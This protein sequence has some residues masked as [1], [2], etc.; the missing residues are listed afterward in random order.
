MTEQPADSR[1]AFRPSPTGTRTDTILF[2]VSMVFWVAVVV[3]AAAAPSVGSVAYGLVGLGFLA[4]NWRKYRHGVVAD[5]A[6]LHRPLRRVLPWDEVHA[7]EEP[8]ELRPELVLWCTDGKRRGTLLPIEYADELSRISGR[9]I[10]TEK[11]MQR[12]MP[13]VEVRKTWQQEQDDFAARAARVEARN[14]E[15]L[16]ETEIPRGSSG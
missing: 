5:S 2:I 10:Q 15:L 1:I 7:I 9:P 6:G 11:V 8:S 16:G 14:A 12:P 4:Y 3:H 13:K